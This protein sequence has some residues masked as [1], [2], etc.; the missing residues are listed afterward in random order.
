[1]LLKVYQKDTSISIFISKFA[2]H[3]VYVI[4]NIQLKIGIRLTYSF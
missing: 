4:T 2:H 3:L 1:M